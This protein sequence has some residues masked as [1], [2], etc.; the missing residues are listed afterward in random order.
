MSEAERKKRL[1]YKEKRKKWIFIQG[2]AIAVVALL[3]FGSVL[4]YN[5]LN[6]EIYIEYQESSSVK[7]S[8]KI[9]KNAPFYSDYLEEFEQYAD[10]NGDLWIPSS[11]AYPTMAA[12]TIKVDLDYQLNMGTRDVDYEYT[13][14]IVAYPEVVDAAS[15]SKFPMPKTVISESNTPITQNSNNRLIITKPVE[16]DYHYYDKLVKD[17]VDKMGIKN[18]T[19]NLII[20]MEV[21]VIGSSEVFENNTENTYTI[22]VS[23]PLNENAFDV[24]YS[25]SSGQ[26]GDCKILARKNA[27]N[28]HVFGGFAVAFGCI[29][30]LLL[31]TFIAYVYL[32]R[33]HDVK[34]TIKVQRLLN[35]YRSF[36]QQVM[37]GFDT[38]GYQLL[39]IAT[40]KEMLA[41]RDTIQS[42]VLMSENTDQT[43]TQFFIPTNTKILY[44]FEIKVDNYD[45]LYGSHPEWTDDS[46]IKLETSRADVVEDID[47]RDTCLDK[48]TEATVTY[49]ADDKQNDLILTLY[50]EIQKLREQIATGKESTEQPS[51]KLEPQIVQLPD[52]T[53]SLKFGNFT[54]TGDVNINYHEM[55]TEDSIKEVARMIAEDLGDR[56]SFEKVTGEITTKITE[57]IKR[58]SNVRSVSSVPVAPIRPVESAVHAELV[59]PA[60]AEEPVVAAASAKAEETV[61]PVKAE[62]LVVTEKPVAPAVREI[63]AELKK[64]DAKAPLIIPLKD[65]NGDVVRFSEPTAEDAIEIAAPA[66]I[67]ES[68]A[69]EAGEVSVAPDELNHIDL[70]HLLN[71]FEYDEEHECFVDEEGHSFKIQCRRSFTANIIQADPDTVKYY[72]SE[73]KN[74]AL[75]YKGV[76]ARMS[77]RYEAFKKGR[78]HLVRMKIRGK[79]ICLYCAL[80]PEQFD[81]T[82]Y[83]QEAIDA[84]MFE[85]VPMLVK[86]KSA[87]GL[88]RAIE[89]IDA[90][91][92]K[93]GIKP[94][95][96]ANKVDYVAEYPYETTK[97]LVE[98]G[99]VRI[100]DNDY[101]A[102]I[103]DEQ[104]ES[105]PQQSEPLS[106]LDFMLEMAE[107][108]SDSA[109]T[110]A[111]SIDGIS[112]DELEFDENGDAINPA[113]KELNIH[114]K[115][116]FTA[117]LMQSDPKTV[118]SYYN[119]LK[120]Y[121][122]SFKGIK[123]K[124]A[125][126]YETYKKGR[127]QLFRI[128]IK[129]KGL[130]LYCA[131]EPSSVDESRYF[132]DVVTA[133]D[134]SEIPT[135]VRIRTERGLKR[136][137]ELVDAVMAKFDIKPNPKAKE[138][139]YLEFYPFKKTKELVEAGFVKILSDSYKIKEPKAPKMPK[140]KK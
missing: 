134:Y 119:E 48:S 124:T 138:V 89:L 97:A 26:G 133:K 49:P 132:H 30:L 23:V 42:P 112:L 136:A 118:K 96:K 17:F 1:S 64:A 104:L 78:E 18:A 86:V 68:N 94:N 32:T 92:E 24:K 98:K 58:E 99:L 45:E 77:W 21:E 87:R 12:T 19:E 35:S 88:K 140:T 122:L 71:D 36:I 6:K 66:Y 129:G 106:D 29:E 139:D 65:E 47:V 76:K 53:G 60:K 61:S 43:R 107:E 93:A 101:H 90:T 137:K 105:N 117:N 40:F 27:G 135:M 110:L 109:E 73:L 15:K 108:L 123:A 103:S 22:N 126:R 114:C 62:E 50:S 37:N 111:Q 39:E 11:Y 69:D 72:Y 125:W 54:A 70:A 14:R 130:C 115:R 121:I 120:N 56:I 116:S 10:E 55:P 131:L 2:V 80:D 63:T 31:I 4:V 67:D 3:I 25:I 91:M 128:R 20:T 57:V 95:P 46:I 51:V 9:P 82:K 85:C 28:Q 41:I 13:Y 59:E 84:K 33:N 75:S 8:V 81:K 83:F 113:G 102:V 100:L 74:H 7:Y 52:T 44:V 38:T 5:Q 16:I 34:Y 127:N 79:S